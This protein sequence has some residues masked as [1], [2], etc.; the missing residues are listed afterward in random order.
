MCVNHHLFLIFVGS[1]LNL[2][3]LNSVYEK[4]IKAAGKWF[5]LG[6][7]L[8]VSPNT[9]INISDKHRDNETCLREML[10]AHLNTATLT[11]SEICQSLRA[12]IVRLDA[13]A[14]AIE[15]ACTGM[16]SEMSISMTS[17]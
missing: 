9:L 11:Y 6:L 14:E 16:N 5:N 4:L 3:D 17:A 1:I 7:A 12:P 10:I 15:E 8:K 13:L 2:D